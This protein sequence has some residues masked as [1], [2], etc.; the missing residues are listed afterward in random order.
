MA[1]KSNKVGVAGDPL[2]KGGFDRAFPSGGLPWPKGLRDL[3][4]RRGGLSA[5][6]SRPSDP[7]ED[8]PDKDGSKTPPEALG[9]IGPDL[10]RRSDEVLADLDQAE[11]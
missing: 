5:T 10:L 2:L 11:A 6:A 4:K 3:A 8:E 9:R 1:I 7:A